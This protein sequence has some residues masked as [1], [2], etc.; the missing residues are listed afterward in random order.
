MWM[1]DLGIHAKHREGAFYSPEWDQF[2][3][4]PLM[5]EYVLAFRR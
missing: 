1:S 2:T 3:L 4:S 5:V